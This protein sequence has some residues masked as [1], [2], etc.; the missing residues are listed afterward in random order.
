VFLTLDHFDDAKYLWAFDDL[1]ISTIIF[2]SMHVHT[3]RD[4][5]CMMEPT[6]PYDLCMGIR[7][8]IGKVDGIFQRHGTLWWCHV[9]VDMGGSTNKN[10]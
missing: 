6:H 2:G 5:G 7:W 1:I 8:N 3:S 10:I 9:A 4:K